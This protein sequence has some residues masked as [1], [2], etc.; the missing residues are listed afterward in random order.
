MRQKIFNSAADRKFLEN[1]LHPLIYKNIQE[2]IKDIKKN[3]PKRKLFYIMIIVPLL[4]ETRLK[5]PAHGTFEF[6]DKILVVD[7]PEAL[8][9]ERTK[10][11]DGLT[12]EDIHKIIRSQCSRQERLMHADDVISNDSTLGHLKLQVDLLDKKYRL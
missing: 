3:N 2:K 12:E 4:V 7:S 10:K 9:I 1:L 6:V 8:Q 11:R 5:S